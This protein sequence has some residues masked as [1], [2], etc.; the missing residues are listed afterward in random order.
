MRWEHSNLCELQ[1]LFLPPASLNADVVHVHTVSFFGHKAHT[2]SAHLCPQGPPQP[3]NW[4]LAKPN[5]PTCALKT[6]GKRKRFAN[7]CS[8][9]AW[10]RASPRTRKQTEV[11]A[12]ILS[13]NSQTSFRF[14]EQFQ[15]SEIV[16]S[17]PVS[18]CQPL[19]DRN[20]AVR[21]GRACFQAD[22]RTYFRLA[23]GRG[24]VSSHHTA[25][26]ACVL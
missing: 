17:V 7:H 23:D 1:P 10:T 24:A 18:A 9:S 13:L 19:A 16:R 21:L 25:F 3:S 8:A 15:V 12:A 14:G 6:Y 20:Y 26:A 4:R 22:S 11:L 5:A 2:P